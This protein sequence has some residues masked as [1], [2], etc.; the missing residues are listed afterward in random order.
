VKKSKWVTA[1][2]VLVLTSAVVIAFGG[3]VAIAESA[4][5]AAEATAQFAT[6]SVY[7]IDPAAFSVPIAFR[8]VPNSLAD[9]AAV[10]PTAGH[11]HVR[12][13]NPISRHQ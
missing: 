8:V 1:V 12:A 10:T 6:F 3:D 13:A 2:S 5:V 4:L 7:S 11:F 9:L